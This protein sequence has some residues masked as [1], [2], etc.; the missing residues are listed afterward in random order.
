MASLEVVSLLTCKTYFSIILG[1]VRGRTLLRK[2]RGLLDNAVLLRPRSLSQGLD[3]AL[4]QMGALPHSRSK[5]QPLRGK[6]ID[7]A[8]YSLSSTLI[9][10]LLP[11]VRGEYLRWEKYL[12]IVLVGVALIPLPESFDIVVLAAQPIRKL[13]RLSLTSSISLRRNAY[14][15]MRI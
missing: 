3:L 12:L 11:V 10:A 6:N 1:R 2:Q 9:L 8:Q 13:N 14:C 7:I 5:R 4:V 15:Y